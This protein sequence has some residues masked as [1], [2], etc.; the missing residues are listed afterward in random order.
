MRTCGT[1]T[2]VRRL[3]LDFD[4]EGGCPWVPWAPPNLDAM[5]HQLHE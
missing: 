2:L 4:L 3:Y 1:D 5:V